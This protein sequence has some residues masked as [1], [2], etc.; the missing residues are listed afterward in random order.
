MRNKFKWLNLNINN[1]SARKILKLEYPNIPIY[2]NFVKLVDKKPDAIIIEEGNKKYTAREILDLIN[3][4]AGFLQ[5]QDINQNDTVAVLLPNSIWF[6]IA[7][8]ASFKNKSRVTLVNPRLAEND[9]QYQLIDSNTRILITNSTFEGVLENIL[10]HYQLK[11]LIQTDDEKN[12]FGNAILMKEILKEDY[13]EVEGSVSL[14]ETAFLL[15]SGGTTGKS[16]GVM[17][18][19]ANVLANAIQFNAW[20]KQIPVKYSGSVLSALPLCHS[21]GLQCGFFAPILRGEKIIILPKFDPKEVLKIIESEKVT[22]FYGVPTMYI[23]LLRLNVEEYDLSSLKVCVSG[24][25]ALAR[26]VHEEFEK[27]TR[28][29]IVEG[30]GLT[31]CSPVTH[32]NPF[33]KPKVNSIGKP[34]P[35]TRVKLINTET[36]EEVKEGEVGEIIIKGPQVMKGY[37]GKGLESVNIFTKQGWL[38]TGDLATVDQEDYYFL[39]DRAKD[40][41]NSGG[42]KIYP[43]EVEEVLF[44]HPGVS[45]A[46]V[47]PVPDDY[48]GEVGKA[49]II[50]KEGIALTD[51]EMKNFCI[52]QNMTKYKIPKS[53]VF[54]EKVPLSAAGKVLKRELVNLYK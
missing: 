26:K 39:V 48:F 10:K 51:E 15:Y 19:H 18:S 29:A 31:E 20:A 34:L 2:E 7:I 42:L 45:L 47:I 44:K 50:T 37:W 46:A 21:F 33:A 16:K 30:Y 54:V 27:R 11:T 24:G 35:D 41:I 14:E 40:I 4:L 43:R 17:L 23:A 1:N 13:P 25:A 8:F 49:I 38:R 22:S 32:I 9:I 36:Q 53:F 5:T 12:V 28:I 3:R 6:V 52:E